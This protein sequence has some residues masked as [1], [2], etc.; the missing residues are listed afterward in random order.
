MTGEKPRKSKG[1]KDAV[2]EPDEATT[3]EA[4][5]RANPAFLAENPAL[6]R[7]LAPPKRVHGERLADHMTAM[8]EA[9]RVRG[10]EL[11][12]TLED[13]IAHGRANQ[14]NQA[15]ANQAILALLAARTPAEA[16]DII[17]QDWP[18][19]LGVDVVTVCA[20][21]QA[22]TG[23]RPLP[24]GTVAR[25]LP[26]SAPIALRPQAT[27]TVALYGEAAALVASD[28]LARL[29]LAQGGEAMI[30]CG[31]RDAG[32]FEPRQGTELVAFLAAAV[33]I[34]LGRG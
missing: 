33:S 8:L 26:S 18:D 17:G 30:A 3:V 2:A 13:L 14:A 19:L 15:R 25:L 32:H 27:D 4:F 9:E 16:F 6:Y 21:G 31:S 24:R 28:A 11:R 5:L 34:A 12:G 29:T 10:T 20:E 1:G 7:A 22:V 23:A